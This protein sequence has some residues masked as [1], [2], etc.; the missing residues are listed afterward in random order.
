LFAFGTGGPNFGLHITHGKLVQARFHGTG[1]VLTK[2]HDRSEALQ[3]VQEI[4]RNVLRYA[5]G[6]KLLTPAL[7][8]E[9]FIEVFRQSL[10]ALALEISK[11]K[12]IHGDLLH[13]NV[14]VLATPQV[15]KDGATDA[16]SVFIGVY[17]WLS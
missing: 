2:G 9:G 12:G 5:E 1:L 17:R 16:G 14:A 11:G 13:H 4:C 8:E 6:Q 15:G 3:L 7:E 10:S